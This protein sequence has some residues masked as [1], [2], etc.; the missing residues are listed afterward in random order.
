MAGC[1]EQKAGRSGTQCIATVLDLWYLLR[2]QFDA[3]CHTTM[4]I[5][6]ARRAP[7]HVGLQL[8]VPLFLIFVDRGSGFLFRR[9]WITSSRSEQRRS[10]S[11]SFPHFLRLAALDQDDTDEPLNRKFLERNSRWV[12]LVDDELAIRQA[13]GDYLYDQGYQVTACAD[14]D[15]FF[16][17]CSQ[18]LTNNTMP[19]LPDAVVSD[20]RMPGKDGIELLRMLRDDERLRRIP[21]ILLTA[22]GM[23]KDRIVGFQSGADAYLPKPFSPDE[24]LSILDNLIQRRRQ[25]QGERGDL[26]ELKQNMEEI[27]LLMTQNSQ[28]VVKDTDVYL[29][30]SE[31]QVLELLCKGYT[32]AEIAEEKGVS[33]KSVPKTITRLYQK[34]NTDTRTALVRWA[35]QT[36]YIAK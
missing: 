19:S 15:A 25:M 16:E 30:P 36:G 29:T 11:P 35:I 31:R 26:D 13:V 23:T 7:L 5:L 8:L 17:V 34:T 20:I 4:R 21:V 10:S 1:R 28:N 3:T 12:V 27:K 24:L 33:V 22:K 6:R 14:T 32:T 9:L 18:Q 2:P